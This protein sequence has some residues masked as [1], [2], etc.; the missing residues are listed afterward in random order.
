[1]CRVVLLLVVCCFALTAYAVPTRY[2]DT[3]MASANQPSM[4]C[5]GGGECAFV[6]DLV[7]DFDAGVMINFGG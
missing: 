2:V 3:V 7:V 1:M 6:Y 5:P 4:F